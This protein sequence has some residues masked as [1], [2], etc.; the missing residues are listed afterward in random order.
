MPFKES[1]NRIYVKALY[2]YLTFIVLLFVA[3]SCSVE[4]NT[5]TT[6]FYHGLTA[7]YN[8]YFNGK[9]HFLAGVSKVNNA[10]I[11]DYAQMLNLFEFSDPNTVSAC[12]SDMDAAM[13]KASKLI[14]LKS[15]TALPKEKE[16][17]RDNID[18]DDAL[19][20]RKEYNEWVDDAYLLIGKSQFYKHLYDDAYAIFIYCI[21]QANDDDIKKEAAI[22]NARV[23]AEQSDFINANRGINEVELPINASKN[24]KILYYT[25][26]SDIKIKQKLYDEAISPLETALLL[27]KDKREKY[28]YSF[29]LAQLYQE[30]GNGSKAVQLYRKVVNMSPPY[31]V[32][33]NAQVNM[34]AALESGSGDT[35][36]VRRELE[37]MLR[38]SKNDEYHDQIYYALG[39]LGLKENNMEE[40]ISYF[41]KSVAE[42]SSNTN[43]KG[44]S[45]LALADYFYDKNDLL[46]AG[47]YYD[48]ATFFLNQRYHDY[49]AILSKSNNL[50]AVV[51][52]LRVIQEQD[53]LQRVASMPESERDALINSIIAKITEAEQAAETSGTSDQYNVGQFYENE[54]RFQDN[55]EQEGKWYFYNQTAL[56]FGRTEFKRL[57][58]NRALEDNWR[59]ANKTT[60]SS[61]GSTDEENSDNQQVGDTETTSTLTSGKVADNKT[62]EY[63]SRNLPLT[64]TL[65]AIS[66]NKIAY[67]YMNAGKAYRER[68][69]DNVTATEYFEKLVE[70]YPQHELMP[71]ALYHLYDINKESNSSKA[72]NYR[73]QLIQEYPETEYA[74]ILSDPNYFSKKQAESKQSELLY[75]KAYNYYV[76]EDF[77]AA[78]ALC[79][80]VITDYPDDGLAPK[81]MLLKAY[82]TARLTDERSYKEELDKLV[83]KYP[84]TEEGIR[85]KEIIAFLNQEIPELQIEEDIEIA[86]EIYNK[87]LTE[88]HVVAVIINNPEFNLNQ[89]NFDVI[90]HNIDNYTNKNYRT[91]GQLVDNKYIIITIAG[92]ANYEEAFNYYDVFDVAK[93]I[94]NP[95][96]DKIYSF[97]ISDS[98]LSVLNGDKN[99][100]RYLLYF[101]ENFLKP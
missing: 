72:N 17:D 85:A 76:S 83:D 38:D 70:R 53:S 3:A 10:Y 98:N 49:Q 100:D 81:F 19:L 88:N 15:I 13:V 64:D 7:R 29:L 77:N 71:E 47:T 33:F 90:S 45:Y 94:R 11:D 32:Q 93:A 74:K 75:E 86:Q 39:N 66:N 12:S 42:Q 27:T 43:Q 95:S 97:V 62:K 61:S 55:I 50:N 20:N 79:N 4:K 67:A 14:K 37:R 69:E 52:E 36:S 1:F 40:A 9:E 56:T 22:W 5:A 16:R 57:Y 89:A 26:I 87:N 73:Q 91:Q 8:I 78:I 28:R 68:F 51:N 63:Y 54:R 30:V 58:G 41:H 99:P 92:F 25:T 82:C 2:K 80:N 59:R 48:S 23:Y 44:R 24:L 65:M 46:T 34:A 101:Q 60:V 31:E 35:Q 18:T 84:G 96:L 21:E 6:R